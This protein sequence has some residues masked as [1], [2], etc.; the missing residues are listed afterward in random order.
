MKRDLDTVRKLLEIFEAAPAGQS[1]QEFTGN[2]GN[3]TAV[4]IIS[5]IE[6]LIDSKLVEGEAYPE[7][8]ETG[9]HFWVTKITWAGY[10]FLDA[11]RNDDIWNVTKRK[12]MQVGS[13]TF[14]LVV[15]LLK[16]E[17][18]RRLGIEN[19]NS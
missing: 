4:E 10:D 12:V 13:W 15:E 8:N 16:E 2:F 14:S 17:A 11:S 9:G 1:I 3:L 18:K 6:L 7:D 5:H 19:S